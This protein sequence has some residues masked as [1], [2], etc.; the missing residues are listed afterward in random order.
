M[1]A[2]L[3]QPFY[4]PADSDLVD[5]LVAQRDEQLRR[6]EELAGFIHDGY[7]EAASYFFNANQDR[8][9]RYVSTVSEVFDIDKARPYIDAVYWQRALDLTDI[10]ECMPQARKDSWREQIEKR[11][12]PEFTDGNVR[13]T[14]GDLLV[15]RSKFIAEKADGVFRRLSRDHVTNVPEGFGKRFIMGYCFGYGM[16]S[17]S[18]S[19]YLDDLREIIAK[20]MGRATD[21]NRLNGMTVMN[22]AR[23]KR[24]GEWVELDGRAL[25]I[26]C[27]LKGTMHI[28]VHPDIAWRLNQLLHSLYPAAIPSRFR[29]PPKKRAKIP[30]VHD[31]PLS[32]ECLRVLRDGNMPRGENRWATPYTE[33]SK[34]ATKEAIQVVEQLGGVRENGFWHFAYD[35]RE[36]LS[37]IQASGVVPDK[38]SHQF[39]PT[40]PEIVVS[41]LNEAGIHPGHSVID[42]SAGTGAVADMIETVRQPLCVEISPLHC[43]VLESKN[44]RVIE[45]DFIEWAADQDMLLGS[46]DRIVMNPPYS[47]GRAMAHLE[48][49]LTLLAPE[50][51]LVALV[52]T[53][54][55][56]REMPGNGRWGQT[57]ERFP[58]TS[59]SVSIYVVGK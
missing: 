4:A 8:F 37:D 9:N 2:I 56:N 46:Y 31:R 1:G 42:P 59:I 23:D 43:R 14:I 33:H 27:Y 51:V 34:A 6:C 52:P 26:R 47:E 17:T 54:Y 25:K 45:A 13:A 39:Y 28:E 16:A 15:M 57:F 24:R 21:G 44:H 50:G 40:P 3:D 41:M 7:S 18:A 11:E 30:P 38:I 49:A 58:G 35:P 55:Q 32:F 29:N 12:T 22:Y 10:F 5:G 36:A 20:Y 19:G 48:A 53:T